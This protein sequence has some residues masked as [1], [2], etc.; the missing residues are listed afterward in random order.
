MSI[1]LPWQSI[2]SAVIVAS[3]SASSLAMGA[4]RAARSVSSIC[5][6]SAWAQ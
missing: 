1:G 3:L 4:N 5:A 6:A 2:S